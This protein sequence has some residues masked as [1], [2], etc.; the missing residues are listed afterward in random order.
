[1][2]KLLAAC[3]VLIIGI[4]GALI[5]LSPYGLIWHLPVSLWA[6]VYK[7]ARSYALKLWLTIDQTINT[8]ILGN[9][10]H[11]ISGRIGYLAISGS[12]TALELE[13]FVDW[14]FWPGH[15]RASVEKD[16]AYRE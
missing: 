12:K 3:I 2:A 8:V 15:C 7:P 5:L 16:R 11:T 4:M 13:K 10:D 6:V 1:M 14:L 9:E